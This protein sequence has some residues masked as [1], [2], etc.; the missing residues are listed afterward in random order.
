MPSSIQSAL[1][2]SGIQAERIEQLW[3][4]MFWVCTVV[5]FLVMAAVAIAITRGRSGASV[6][7]P[8]ST[9]SR[10]VSAAVALS[11]VSL[12]G[13]LFADVMTGRALASLASPGAL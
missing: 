9:I 2:S 11:I 5:F 13:L 6:G 4:L 7:T 3:W 1:H 10:Y 8:S 12:L